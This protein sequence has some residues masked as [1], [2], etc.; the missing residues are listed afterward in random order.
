MRI[1]GID[2][3]EG[4]VIGMCIGEYGKGK[5]VFSEE[6]GVADS[7]KLTPKKRRLL[8]HQIRKYA[9]RFTFLRYRLFRSMSCVRL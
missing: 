6:S 1:A 4:P 8:A 2:E 5:A 7:K 9:Q 3:A